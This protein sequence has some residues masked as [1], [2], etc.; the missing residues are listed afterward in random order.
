MYM[1]IRYSLLLPWNCHSEIHLVDIASN[2]GSLL[3]FFPSS[4]FLEIGALSRFSGMYFIYQMHAY[5]I[6]TQ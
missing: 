6:D 3:F 4:M 2:S 5:H 1:F